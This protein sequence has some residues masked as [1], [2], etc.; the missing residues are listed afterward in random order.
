MMFDTCA[1]VHDTILEMHCVVLLSL[2]DLVFAEEHG[3]NIMEVT[4]IEPNTSGV[5]NCSIT[6]CTT[7]MIRVDTND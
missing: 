5:N 4:R 6:T 3:Q 7:V 2:E 1:V